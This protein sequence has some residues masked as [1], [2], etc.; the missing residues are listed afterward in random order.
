M[1]SVKVGK[2][3]NGVLWKGFSVGS[4]ESSWKIP[5]KDMLGRERPWRKVLNKI[6]KFKGL[7]MNG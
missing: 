5:V 7:N 6:I 3:I 2:L 1:N 4:D